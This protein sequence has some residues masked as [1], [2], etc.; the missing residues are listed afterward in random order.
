MVHSGSFLWKN[1]IGLSDISGI[2]TNYKHDNGSVLFW[3]DLRA[4][5]VVISKKFKVVFFW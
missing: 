3:G 5:R 1:V 4:R 2:F